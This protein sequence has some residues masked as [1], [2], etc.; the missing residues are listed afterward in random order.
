MAKDAGLESIH[1]LAYRYATLFI[2]PSWRGISD[3]VAQTIKLPSIITIV[4]RLIIE[5]IQLQW[6]HS[7]KTKTATG[8]TADV[9]R[10]LY[11]TIKL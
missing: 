5:A 8:R 1:V 10:R 9:L 3:Q 6:I 2:H 7:K 4:H 11:E